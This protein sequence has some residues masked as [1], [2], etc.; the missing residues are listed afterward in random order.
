MRVPVYTTK[1]RRDAKLVQKRNYNMPLLK[2]AMK[3]LEDGD[4][5]PQIYKE[6][7]LHG[8]Y[9]GKLECHIEPDWL[10]IYRISD[11]NTEVVFYRTGTH[12]DLY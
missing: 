4:A 2:K 9:A 7:P 5:L 3:F 10:L 12:S 1:F 11:D 6:H 8:N